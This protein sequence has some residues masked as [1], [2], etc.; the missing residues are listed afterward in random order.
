[1][2][3]VPRAALHSKAQPVVVFFLKFEH[4]VEQFLEDDLAYL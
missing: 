4:F 3:P 1:M 2:L